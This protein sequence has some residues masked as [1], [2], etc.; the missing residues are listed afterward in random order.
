M[1]HFELSEIEKRLDNG[2]LGGFTRTVL[3]LFFEFFLAC[4]SILILHYIFN[5]VKV[6]MIIARVDGFVMFISCFLFSYRQFW[7]WLNIH[8]CYLKSVQGGY[9]VKC[10][11]CNKMFLKFWIWKFDKFERERIYV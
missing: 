9:I 1:N 4:I 8:K 2:I 5:D 6:E 10:V 7:L 11:S 3:L